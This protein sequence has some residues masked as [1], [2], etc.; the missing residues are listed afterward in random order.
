VLGAVIGRDGRIHHLRVISSPDMDLSLA[1]FYCVQ[2]WVYKPYVL[3]GQPVEVNTQ[4]NVIFQL[5]N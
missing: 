3:Q 2:Q 5:G 1:S 4:I